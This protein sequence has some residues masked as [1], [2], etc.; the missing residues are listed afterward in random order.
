LH[1]DIVCEDENMY[2]GKEE[3]KAQLDQLEANIKREREEAREN[4]AVQERL[5]KVLKRVL[6]FKN[7]STFN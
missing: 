2:T 1:A 4:A 7:N 6:K 5:K 3:F